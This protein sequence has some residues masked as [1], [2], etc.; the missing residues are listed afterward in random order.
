M[1]EA[2]KH[3]LSLDQTLYIFPQKLCKKPVLQPASIRLRVLVDCL[4]VVYVD[5]LASEFLFPFCA[6]V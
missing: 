5:F 2:I 6:I 3:V 1:A 4:C